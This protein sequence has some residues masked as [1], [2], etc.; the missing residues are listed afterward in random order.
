MTRRLP[1]GEEWW[2]GESPF[3][4][5][6]KLSRGICVLSDSAL[7]VIPGLEPSLEAPSGASLVTQIWQFSLP[8]MFGGDAA[9]L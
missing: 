8:H 6:D 1:Q 5:R 7:Y 2:G 9:T 3:N 4:L